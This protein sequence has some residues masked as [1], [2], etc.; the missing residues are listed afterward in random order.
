MIK[1]VD[2]NTHFLKARIS[3]AISHGSATHEFRHVGLTEIVTDAG[4]VGWG[5]GLSCPSRRVIAQ[6]MLGRDASN[7]ESICREI[8]DLGQGAFGFLSG[9]D[10]A[11]HDIA[12]KASQRPVYEM[13]G[14]KRRTEIRAYASGL[15]RKPREDISYLVEEARGYVDRGFRDI[16]MKVGFDVDED[17]RIVTAVRQEI[18]NSISLA[19]DANCAYSVSEAI[20]SLSHIYP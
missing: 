13:F 4:I 1:I 11:L 18:G 17:I 8:A 9:I 20:S 3:E 7:I 2:V 10:I 16:K 14:E 15:Y 5:E 12:G 6:Y 19:I